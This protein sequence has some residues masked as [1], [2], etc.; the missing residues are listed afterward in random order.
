MMRHA[1]MQPRYGLSKLS[2]GLVSVLLGATWMGMQVHADTV[3]PAQ[4]NQ[5]ASEKVASAGSAASTTGSTMVLKSS[6]T[7]T[8]ATDNGAKATTSVDTKAQATTDGQNTNKQA[9][10]AND[11][12]ANTPIKYQ[13]GQDGV[14]DVMNKYVTRTVNFMKD[15]GTTLDH[16]VNQTVHFVRRD[17]QGNAGYQ[18]KDGNITYFN[19]SVDGN[20]TWA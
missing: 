13:A 1:N 20:P 6:T 8:P 17:E 18:D 5:P 14:N 4:A 16:A 7:A 12:K 11:T 9:Q 19:W 15:D 2:L 3:T 10:A